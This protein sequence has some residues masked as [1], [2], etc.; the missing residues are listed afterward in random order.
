MI[1]NMFEQD[2]DE[3]NYRVYE[4]HWKSFQRAI[5]QCKQE[6]LALGFTKSLEIFNMDDHADIY[7]LPKQDFLVF[8]AFSQGVDDK[9]ISYF[10]YIGVST[11]NDMNNERHAKLISYLASRFCSGRAI[12]VVDDNLNK[13]GAFNIQNTTRVL[14]MSKED[15]R[16][17]QLISVDCLSTLTLS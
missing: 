1:D 4:Y 2:V 8:S 6:M 11:F 16:S 5:Q 15:L 3:S 9:T 12:K 17:L 14:P 10:F 13:I 7:K